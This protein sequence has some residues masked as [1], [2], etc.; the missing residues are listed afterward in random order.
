MSNKKIFNELNKSKKIFYPDRQPDLFFNQYTCPDFKTIVFW[1]ISD[2]YNIINT[3]T[4]P[5]ELI[6]G[7]QI[8]S[9]ILTPHD[10]NEKKFPELDPNQKYDFRKYHIEQTHHGY[11]ID[12]HT[13][14]NA[15]DYKASE[16]A[17]ASF[18][19]PYIQYGQKYSFAYAYFLSNAKYDTP[20]FDQINQIAYD[21]L[22][23]NAR[24]TT[25]KSEKCL[26]GVLQ[27]LNQKQQFFYSETSPVLFNKNIEL[28]KN[29]N[30]IPQTKPINDY[31]PHIVLEARTKAIDKAL[32]DFNRD[33]HATNETFEYYVCRALRNARKDIFDQTGKFPEA[34]IT[35]IPVNKV[36]QNL[37]KLETEFVEKFSTKTIIQ[38]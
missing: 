13:Y 7:N 17:V 37:K 33:K 9:R 5:K 16:Y 10:F 14:K 11:T 34:L 3:P 22:R 29:I 12:H 38:R 20:T 2:L 26:S 32:A 27:R 24:K 6:Y 18:L 35:K 15:I 1:H 19:K 4:I 25:A 36:E 8:L 28:L 23:I 30:G 31:L 21:I